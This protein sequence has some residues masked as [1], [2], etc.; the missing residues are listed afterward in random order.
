MGWLQRTCSLTV[1]RDIGQNRL[2]RVDGA[3]INVTCVTVYYSVPVGERSIA[4]SLSDCLSVRE[5]ISGIAGP[6]FTKFF[7]PI[8]CGRGSIFLWR[9]CD[10]LCT[11]GFIDNVTFGRSGPY[12]ASGVATPGTVW[13]LW[14]P[15]R[16]WPLPDLFLWRNQ[17]RTCLGV[18]GHAVSGNSHI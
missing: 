14:M 15:C 17:Y 6:T 2:S 16:P 11:S 12:G 4:I 9:R 8:P 1:S 10:T 3:H 5:H 18:I 7:V 13:C